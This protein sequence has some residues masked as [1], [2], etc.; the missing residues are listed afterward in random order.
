MWLGLFL[1]VLLVFAILASIVSGGIFTIIV[2]PV[3]VIVAVG[4][5]VF[6][7]WGRASGR[8][9]TGASQKDSVSA[10]PD[11]YPHSTHS[12]TAPAPATA[13]QLVDAKR[14]AQ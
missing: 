13:D 5:L 9:E 6:S 12:N 7:L 2:L 3:A 1:A 11:A 8:G 10:T 14:Q 4:A